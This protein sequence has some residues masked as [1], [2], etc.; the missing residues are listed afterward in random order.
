M[1][2]I[3][4]IMGWTALLLGVIGL[5]FQYMPLGYAAMLIGLLCLFFKDTRGMGITSI[6][7]GILLFLMLNIWTEV[8][9][10]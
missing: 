1:K 6:G 2:V 9:F 3:L 5:M 4:G 7:F 8:G 10:V